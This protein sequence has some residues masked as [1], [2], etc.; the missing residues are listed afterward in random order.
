MAEV[1]KNEL[2]GSPAF[3]LQIDLKYSL[4]LKKGFLF[5]SGLRKGK[6]I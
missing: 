2:L 1:P 6:R 5:K 4:R 3:L